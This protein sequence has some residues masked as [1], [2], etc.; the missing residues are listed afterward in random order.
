MYSTANFAMSMEIILLVPICAILPAPCT[1]QLLAP[2]IPFLL[3]WGNCSPVT[4]N[5]LLLI[6][7]WQILVNY[8]SAGVCVRRHCTATAKNMTI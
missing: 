1:R 5:Q 8:L 7:V 4:I 2:A 3:N 6:P